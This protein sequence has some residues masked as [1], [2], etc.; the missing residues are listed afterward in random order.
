MFPV[1]YNHLNT[2]LKMKNEL[3]CISVI[4]RCKTSIFWMRFSQFINGICRYVSGGA[5]SPTDTVNIMTV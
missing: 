4:F 1:I 2:V 3:K 5:Y